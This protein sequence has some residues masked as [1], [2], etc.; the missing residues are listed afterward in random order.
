[1]KR[2]RRAVEIGEAAEIIEDLAGRRIGVERVDREIA[3]RGILAPVVGEGDG[4]VAAVGRD[5]AAQRRDLDRRRRSSTAVTVPCARPVGTALIRARLEPRDHLLGASGVAR[6]TSATSMPEQRVAHRAADEA[7][8]A[9]A[10]AATSARRG[11]RALAPAAAG[12]SVMRP[13]QPPRQVD[14]H[15]RGRAPDAAVVPEDLVIMARRGPAIR[16]SPRPGWRGSSRKRERDFEHARRPPPRWAM[17]ARSGGTTPITGVT[18]K[19]VT[20]R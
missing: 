5:V 4:G 2:T 17:S 14:D 3:P 7:R 16:R 6:S 19:P 1:M 8:L 20:V 12:R 13:S 15:R 9:R 10:S 11:P 18:S